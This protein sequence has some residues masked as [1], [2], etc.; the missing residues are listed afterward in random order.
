MQKVVLNFSIANIIEEKLSLSVGSCPEP[1]IAVVNYKNS[2]SAPGIR[3][4]ICRNKYKKRYLTMTSHN[5][6]A[7]FLKRSGVKISMYN[8]FIYIKAILGNA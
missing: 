4:Y 1:T 8:T 3:D 2:T 6:H 5:L 7:K